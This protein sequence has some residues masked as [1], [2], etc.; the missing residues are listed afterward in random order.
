MTPA[1]HH[2]RRQDRAITDAARI[3]SLLLTGRFATF[4]LCDGAEP[5]VVT[6]SYGY[7]AEARRM[8]FHVAHEGRKLDIIRR[9]PVACGTVVHA[10]DYLHGECAHPF[11]SVVLEGRMR[12]VEDAEE[13]QRALLTLVRHLEA[14]PDRFWES[15]SLDDP[16]R[17]AKFTALCFEIAHVSAKAGS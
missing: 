8:Y 17:T 5:Y 2:M 9:N 1:T 6:L 11:E 15:R 12:I 10:G 4:A 13:K 3:D 14:D 16:R 7:D